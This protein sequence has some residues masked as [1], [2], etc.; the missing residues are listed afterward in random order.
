MKN[1]TK[2]LLISPLF[3]ISSCEEEGPV[4]G[5]LDSQACNYNPEATLDNNSCEYVLE[6]FDCN[7]EIGCADSL[8]CNFN[9]EVI[10][11]NNSCE[12]ALQGYD[13]DGNEVFQIGDFIDGG[14]L[15]Y[16]D[17]SNEFGLIAANQDLVG[18]Y[19]WGCYQTDVLGANSQAIGMGLENTT[20]IVNNEC[21]TE[22]GGLSAAEATMSSNLNGYSD[23][24]LPSFY[25]LQ[26]MENNI[27]EQSQLGNIGNFIGADYWSS[28]SGGLVNCCYN[29]WSVKF[30]YGTSINCQCGRNDLFKVRPIRKFFFQ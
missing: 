20:E 14:I 12:Y 28:S 5:C 4:H 17:Y 8:A 26:L 7:D 1:L 30:G 6:G 29:S 25:E 11:N 18:Y 15:F 2:I 27:G 23:W 3:F 10:P 16:I 21:A 22:N 24:F 9:S 19:E 13:C